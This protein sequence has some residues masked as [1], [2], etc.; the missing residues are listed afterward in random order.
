MKRGNQ[1]LA[2]ATLHHLLEICRE[3]EIG[4]LFAANRCQKPGLKSFLGAEALQQSLFIAEL[5][6]ELRRLGSGAMP[7]IPRPARLLGW[8]ELLGAPRLFYSSDETVLLL[9]EQGEKAASGEYLQILHGDLP[10]P[11]FQL[12]ER[13]HAQ[14]LEACDRLCQI[15]QQLRQGEGACASDLTGLSP[16]Y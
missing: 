14:L 13:Q 7:L 4:F 11:V 16:H 15:Q 10:V 12:V 3:S 1:E 2:I 6:L 5:Q 8:K 9:C